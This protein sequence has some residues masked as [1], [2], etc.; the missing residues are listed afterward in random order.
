[1]TGSSEGTVY[2]GGIAGIAAYSEVARSTV[3]LCENRGAVKSASAAGTAYSGGIA[4]LGYSS[5]D[6][7][8]MTV[9]ECLNTGCVEARVSSGTKLAYGGGIVGYCSEKNFTVDGCVNTYRKIVGSAPAG[10]RAGGIFGVFNLSSDE[11]AIV[12]K[13]CLTV[14]ALYGYNKNTLIN[15]VANA[16]EASAAEAA[17]KLRARIG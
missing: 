15:N 9:S 12:C 11:G 14:G 3:R 5:G 16:T 2:A 17:E 13:N 1:M 6:T 7:I 8:D 4:G 10:V